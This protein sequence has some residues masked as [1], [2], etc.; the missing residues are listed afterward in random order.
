MQTFVKTR[1]KKKNQIHLGE[2]AVTKK[3]KLKKKSQHKTKIV[4]CT[5]L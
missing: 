4:I 5:S 3:P 2:L 1:L